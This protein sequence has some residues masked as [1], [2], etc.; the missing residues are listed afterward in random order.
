MNQHAHMRTI[1]PRTSQSR[2]AGGLLAPTAPTLE[3]RS[4]PTASSPGDRIFAWRDS[5]DD[6]MPLEEHGSP[7]FC[8]WSRGHGQQQRIVPLLSCCDG[9]VMQMPFRKNVSVESHLSR[10]FPAH[11]R[12]LARCLSRALRHV[13]VLL[14]PYGRPVG[15]GF[16]IKNLPSA[17]APG[18]PRFFFGAAAE[19]TSRPWER[20]TS[21]RF[22]QEC[23]E[24]N[25]GKYKQGETR[26]HSTPTTS[27]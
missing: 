22:A 15:L 14:R 25:P 8:F 13:D 7:T 19:S 20:G 2:R 17:T 27:P 6:A 18:G 24:S 21:L 23:P 3:L 1:L 11:S 4:S 5:E 26:W 12:S 9:V 10:I 16:Q